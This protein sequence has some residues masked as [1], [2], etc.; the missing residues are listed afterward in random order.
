[1][2]DD[3]LRLFVHLQ[4]RLRRVPVEGYD[5]IVVDGATKNGLDFRLK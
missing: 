5:R 4:W 3:H 1:M 2:R